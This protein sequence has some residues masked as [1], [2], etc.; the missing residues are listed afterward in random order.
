MLLY[1]ILP[2]F[3]THLVKRSGVVPLLLKVAQFVRKCSKAFSDSC[4]R[5]Y[6]YL[7]LGFYSLTICVQIG[8]FFRWRRFLYVIRRRPTVS[9]NHFLISLTWNGSL[10]LWRL[11]NQ[12]KLMRS[13]CFHS[14]KK[15]ALRFL[16]VLLPPYH[17][18]FR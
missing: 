6:I 16:L 7:Q 2:L 14:E 13:L 4:R 3:G 1:D 12:T 17:N 10:H 15:E 18:I 9:S 11:R 5:I 8:E